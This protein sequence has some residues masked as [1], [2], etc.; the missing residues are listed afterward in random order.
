MQPLHTHEATFASCVFLCE[1]VWQKQCGSMQREGA[2]KCNRD[3]K[4][5]S[6]CREK[7]KQWK[8]NKRRGEWCVCPCVSILFTVLHVWAFIGF[9]LACVHFHT[10]MHT[11]I[12][13]VAGHSPIMKQWGSSATIPGVADKTRTYRAV[14]SL[15][16]DSIRLPNSRACLEWDGGV[17]ALSYGP[18]GAASLHSVC[19]ILVSQPQGEA[20]CPTALTDWF[21]IF[22]YLFVLLFVFF[23]LQLH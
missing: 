3:E 1:R 16:W 23:S 15:Y 10:R 18:S 2:I 20:Y 5:E 6:G 22:I 9:S 19:L 14:C 7:N 11:S 17:R 4:E 21:H 12:L 8:W 13:H